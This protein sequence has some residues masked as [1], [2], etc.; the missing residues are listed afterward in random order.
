MDGVQVVGECVVWAACEGLVTTP[1]SSIHHTTTAGQPQPSKEGV[2]RDGS[3]GETD[4]QDS[5]IHYIHTP[6][7]TTLDAFEVKW[8]IYKSPS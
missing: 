3:E 1:V 5:S 4:G 2:I 6:P 8:F 7:F